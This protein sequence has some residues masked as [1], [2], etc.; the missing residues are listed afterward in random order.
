MRS[1]V[2]VKTD[3]ISQLAEE[4]EERRQVWQDNLHR[5]TAPRQMSTTPALE[6]DIYSDYVDSTVPPSE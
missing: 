3:V 4:V 2:E 6:A 5:G 1:F